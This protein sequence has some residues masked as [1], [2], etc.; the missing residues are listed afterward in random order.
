MSVKL[1]KPA[2]PG[3]LVEMGGGCFFFFVLLET[4]KLRISAADI[5]SFGLLAT[6]HVQATAGDREL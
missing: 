2:P 1:A 5:S 3:L 6:L 4:T